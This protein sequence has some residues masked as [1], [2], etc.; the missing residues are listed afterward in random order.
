[1]TMFD[2]Q[3]ILD[4][5]FTEANS[6]V[7]TPVPA[8]EYIAYVEKVDARPWKKRDDPSVGGITLD[9]TWVVDDAGVKALLD[10]EKVTVR[11][12]I[13]LDLTESGG[14]DFGKGKNVGLGK[15]RQALDMNEPGKP[16][17]FTQMTGRTARI[18]VSH[19]ADP[20]DA[21]KVYAEVKSVAKV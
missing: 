4:A 16:F 3:A 5:Q 21:E 9:V 13:M 12:G 20:S 6:T 8:G 17:S 2:P 19:R 15:L 7:A 18:V 14:L 1:M 10:R 11:Q